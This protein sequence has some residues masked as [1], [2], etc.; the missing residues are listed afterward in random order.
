M[1]LVP[2]LRS[3]GSTTALV[4]IGDD[5]PSTPQHVGSVIA[6]A[7]G[8]RYPIAPVGRTD[9]A[10]RHLDTVDWRL[11]EA[12]L[13]LVHSE[14]GRS[15]G[16]L[17][18]S[19]GAA[20]A[21]P[22]GRLSWPA[23]A[24]RIPDG[25]VRDAVRAAAWVR[26][27]LPYA[28]SSASGATFAVCNADEKTVTKI[29][30]WRTTVAAGTDI[31]V[32]IDIAPLRG[33]GEDA[34]AVASLLL[35]A[36]PVARAR[37]SWLDEVRISSGAG[38]RVAAE[39]VMRRDHPAD[40]AV[41]DSL[42]GYL[43]DL[44]STIGGIRHDWD[45]EFLHDLRVAVRRTRSVLKL[46]GDALPDGLAAQ[47]APEFRWLGNVTTLTRDLDVYL[48][49]FEAMAATVTNPLDLG[50]FADHIRGRRTTARR[51]LTRALRSARFE[52]LRA[53]WRAGLATVVTATQHGGLTAGD[54]ADQRLHR[55]YRTVAKRAQAIDADS[56]AA[57]VHALRKKCKELRYLLEVFEPLCDPKAY[58]QVIGD[59][60]KLQN[61]LGEFQDGEV[62]A[63]ALRVYAQEMIDAGDVPASA[64]L[65]MGEL[66]AQFDARQRAARAE[67]TDRHDSYL[68]KRAARHVDRLVAR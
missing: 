30:W 22:V 62:Q 20:L 61:V 42:L 53:E 15:L 13:G 64:I 8:D 57:D 5:A 23:L 60:K 33:Y 6:T 26:A 36:L 12:D 43:S 24:D 25:P 11:H 19:D 35:S 58:R 49:D 38:P 31:P 9:V 59:F 7:L 40:L 47:Y 21:Q 16:V 41:A 67:L 56:P 55:V 28:R 17:H 1:T 2:A 50:P 45:T 52:R 32:R 34:D 46:L 68:G 37:Q 66:S 14:S 3:L 39:P 18:A 54:L 29:T 63:S 51:D 65:A 48:L 10:L 27:L 4:W 44:E